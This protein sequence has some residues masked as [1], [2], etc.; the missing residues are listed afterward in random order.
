M[1]RTLIAAMFAAAS[2]SAT[3]ADFYVVVPVKGRTANSA[4]ISVALSGSTLPGATVGTAYSYSF[5]QNLQVTGDAS[6]NGQ[7]VT[8]TVASGS[9]PEGL[10]LNELTGELTGTPTKVSNGNFLLTAAYKTKSGQQAY[11]FNVSYAVVNNP[12]V[13][14]PS[15]GWAVDGVT[16]TKTTTGW[17]GFAP[18][19]SAASGKYY[20]EVAVNTVVPCSAAGCDGVGII[21]S[22]LTGF[23]GY[24]LE[25]GTAP[26]VYKWSSGA[27][28]GSQY[29]ASAYGAGSIVG[30]ALDLD[31]RTLQ[32]VNAS[33]GC[34]SNGPALSIQGYFPAGS[35]VRPG[36]V[37]YYPTT[38]ITT[39]FTGVGLACTPPVG[40]AG[41]F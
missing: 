26:A 18:N 27:A 11:S 4:L 15:T 25:R 13:L 21:G 10:T 8:W 24:F 41:G 32:F 40:F 20:W 30:V 1:N 3:A 28:V 16:A 37:A 19:K 14:A 6:F 22:Q 9:I 2:F 31:N 29:A 36:F 38:K 23:T 12:A 5:S 17:A 7:G 35:S 33:G 39:N 34:G